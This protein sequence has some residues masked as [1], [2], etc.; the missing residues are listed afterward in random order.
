MAL[1]QQRWSDVPL[2]VLDFEG[3]VRTGVVEFGVTTLLGGEI[4]SVHTGLCAP[5]APIPLM[6]TQCHG[7]ADRDLTGLRTFD[8][9]WEYFVSLRSSGVFV[10]HNSSVETRLL[11]ATWPHPSA[12]PSVAEDGVALAEWGPWVDTLRLARRWA[13]TLGDFRLGELIRMLHLTERL[14]G[15]ANRHCPAG[16]RHYHCAGYDALAAALVLRHLGGLEGRSTLSLAH[17]LAN[18]VGEAES[19]DFHQGELGF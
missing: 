5:L 2:H 8:A 18:S 11:A 6:D 13:P 17:L 19:S 16:R 10:A 15:L 1:N 3:G 9:H 4:I 12:V 7:L 14:D